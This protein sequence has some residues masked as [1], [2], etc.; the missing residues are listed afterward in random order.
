MSIVISEKNKLTT[1]GRHPFYS[2]M[3]EARKPHLQLLPNLPPDTMNTR[4][5]QKI[6]ESATA[7]IKHG[8]TI[9]EVE[10]WNVLP[11]TC[12]NL[13]TKPT[14]CELDQSQVNK[15][16]HDQLFLMMPALWTKLCLIVKFGHLPGL[17]FFFLSW[18]TKSFGYLMSWWHD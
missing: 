7:N 9:T 1:Q 6:I 11:H 4:C 8:M 2:F 12:H 10:Y 13:D 18:V 15:S 16:G 17:V 3:N 14:K 5:V